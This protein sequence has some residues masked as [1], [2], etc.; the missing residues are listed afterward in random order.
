[1]E[2]PKV[3]KPP[4]VYGPPTVKV[5]DTVVFHDAG[6]RGNPR[7]SRVLKLSKCFV[8]LQDLEETAVDMYPPGPDD[9]YARLSVHMR[10]T[11]TDTLKNEKRFK[12]RID[13]PFCAYD[14][15][16]RYVNNWYD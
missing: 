11:P 8:A 3:V 15:E 4:K 2:N 9:G 14:P 10:V 12:K 5:G 16:E 6:G 1:M 7:F 13:Y